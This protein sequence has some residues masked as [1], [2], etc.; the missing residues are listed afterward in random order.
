MSTAAHIV[1]VDDEPLVRETVGEYLARQGYLVSEAD[2]G[3]ALDR[4]MAERAVDL[5]LLDVNMPD[6]DGVSIA[7][8]LRASGRL[9]IIMLTAHGDQVDRVI[10]LEVGADDYV[11]KPPDLREL[12]ARVRSVLRRASVSESNCAGTATMGQVVRFGRCILDLKARKLFE[13]GAEVPLTAMEYDLLRTFAEHPNKA[14]SRDRILDLAHSSEME[15]FDRS[16]DSRIV[17]LRRK[18]EEDPTKP[19]V[20]KTVRGAGYI[21]VPGAGQ[22]LEQ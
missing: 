22:H 18:V 9:G 11:V 1:V 21:F 4:V 16:V 13:D 6:E 2:G 14:L 12:L 15:P 8:R 3:A 5:V 7:R 17:R 20:L 10:G 19:Q